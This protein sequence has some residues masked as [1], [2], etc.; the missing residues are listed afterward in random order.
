LS[1]TNA[2]DLLSTALPRVLNTP[3]G[4]LCKATLRHR[5]LLR[6]IIVV[7]FHSDQHFTSAAVDPEEKRGKIFLVCTTN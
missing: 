4:T 3:G 7:P 5:H 2:R 6:L 1:K